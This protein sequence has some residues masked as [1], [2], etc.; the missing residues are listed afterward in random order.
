MKASKVTKLLLADILLRG[1]GFS[2]RDAIF[3]PV[4]RV[5]LA[6]RCHYKT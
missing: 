1:L 6:V 2:A 3:N 4:P 5:V